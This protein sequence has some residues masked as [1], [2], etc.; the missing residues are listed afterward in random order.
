MA[1]RSQSHILYALDLPPA[2]LLVALKRIPFN[3]TG[4]DKSVIR[5]C[6]LIV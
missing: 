5:F 1:D 6:F 3:K 4:Q 2:S